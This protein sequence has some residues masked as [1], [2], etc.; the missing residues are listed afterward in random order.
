MYSVAQANAIF[1]IQNS[2]KQI[3]KYTEQLN[4]GLRINRAADDASGMA[5]ANQ[6]K[7]QAN[8][9]GQ[10]I[11]NTN[12]GI[13]LMNI[14]DSALQEYSDILQQIRDKASQA[15]SDSNSDDSRAALKADIDALVASA[16]KISTQT[17]YNGITLLD[18]TFTD[19]KFQT[20]AYSGQTTTV[21][22]DSAQVADLGID[23]L[24]VDTSDNASTSLTS[25]DAAIKSLDK[26]R[27][28]I[29]STTQGFESRV[30][31]MTTT[32]VNVESAEGQIRNA[33][34]AEARA[35]VDNWNIRNQAATFAYQMAQQTQQ[36]LL[37]LFQ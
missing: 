28:G 26:I 9:L 32:K 18:G 4:T 14:A 7:S 8:G 36:N 25:I 3:N 22:I 34:E 37:R 35:Q 12:D 23:A 33:D 10:A 21:T 6:L 5:I 15:V 13:S 17:Q 20:G 1:G 24:A 16:Q 27:S 31:N 2:T 19:K 30:R 11:R 29:G